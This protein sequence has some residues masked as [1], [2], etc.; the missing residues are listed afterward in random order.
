MR[1]QIQLCPQIALCS[2]EVSLCH[3][4][5]VDLRDDVVPL[6]RGAMTWPSIKLYRVGE[7]KSTQLERMDVPHST[8]D[9]LP[10]IP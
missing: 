7:L 8:N 10:P 3:G 5:E 1:F 4:L 6:D 2:A 9:T